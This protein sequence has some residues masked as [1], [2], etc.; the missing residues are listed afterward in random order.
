M[1]DWL[2]RHRKRKKLLQAKRAEAAASG[3]HLEVF[4][5]PC[6]Q[7][8]HEACRDPECKCLCHDTEV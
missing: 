6:M 5:R 4:S 8:F 3:R 2:E 7:N 1:A